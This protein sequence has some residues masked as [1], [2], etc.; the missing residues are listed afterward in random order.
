MRKSKNYQEIGNVHDS[1]S[2][3]PPKRVRKVAGKVVKGAGKKVVNAVKRKAKDMRMA[4]PGN[5]CAG[6]KCTN[7]QQKNSI[8]CKRCDTNASQIEYAYSD[9]FEEDDE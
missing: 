6:H 5:R 9:C 4:D 7:P 8:L 2:A 1:Q 3:P